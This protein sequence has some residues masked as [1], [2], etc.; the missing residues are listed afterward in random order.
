MYSGATTSGREKTMSL[1]AYA[2]SRSHSVCKPGVAVVEYYFDG[3]PVGV[4]AE[5][6]TDPG[7]EPDGSLA[8]VKA[9]TILRN[10]GY[11][12]YTAWQYANQR[13]AAD[14]EGIE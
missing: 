9:D 4:V 13:W 11:R 10:L 12:R 14:V 6:D 7:I 8:E 5:S 3:E 2:Y 1:V